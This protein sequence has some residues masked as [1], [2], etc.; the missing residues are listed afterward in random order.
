[1]ET[2]TGT[3]ET[4]SRPFNG[5]WRFAS[6]HPHG[7]VVGHLPE[8]SP[9]DVCIFQGSWKSHPKYGKQ[10]AADHV[11]VETPRDVQ[12]IKAYLARHYD[13]I[14][15][16]I[17][18][19]LVDTFGE[20]LFTVIEEYPDRLASIPGITQARATEIHETYVQIK[21]DQEFDVFFSTHGVT[22]LM[23]AKMIGRYGSKREAIRTIKENPYKLSEDLWG[24]GFKKADA[25]AVSIGIKKDSHYRLSAGLRWALE[26]AADGEGHSYLPKDALF[27]RAGKVLETKAAKKL[28]DAFSKLLTREDVILE[29]DRVYK[30]DIHRAERNTAEKLQALAGTPHER[31]MRELTAELVAEMDQDQQRA[32]ELALTSRVSVITGG[33]GV[34]KTYTVN[35]IIKC[36]GMTEKEVLLA[37]PTGKAAKRMSEMS[38]WPACTIHRLLEYSPFEEG[39]ARDHN[40]PLECKALIVD[41]TSMIDI[42]L[43][44][45]LL[46]AVDPEK[47]Q[48]IFVGDVDQLPSVGPGRVLAD[49]IDSGRIPTARLRTLHRQAAA[50]L[51]NLNA[52]AINRGEKVELGR[53]DSDFVFIEADEPEQIQR[54]M[55]RAVENVVKNLG[56]EVTDV[57][58]LCPQKRGVIG[59]VEMNKALRTILNPG[60]K[61]LE[62]RGTPF[63][64]RDRVIQLRN[65][66]QLGIFNGDIGEVQDEA[67]KETVRIRFDDK[68]IPYPKSHL[69][70]VGLAYALTI[71][72]AQGSEFPVV[73]MPIHTT[74]FLMLRRNLLYTGITRG[75]KL[76]VLVGSRKAVNIATKTVDAAERYTNLCQLIKEGQHGGCR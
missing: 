41:E 21:Q 15:P 5:G 37:A 12:G 20:T 7:T 31:M 10:F 55:T 57:Q 1:M 2:I 49:M 56:Y 61:T 38:G 17:S 30:L 73:I 75:K 67:D 48:M 4:I 60:G 54:L 65:N 33:P 71:H 69:D 40:N 9:G 29:E 16:A 22:L 44:A 58:V 68:E 24:V 39:F 50:S 45:S 46:D 28:E 42:R 74:H 62:V 34:G 63:R 43:M 18:K 23:A 36:M 6:I 11:H 53:L 25:I 3:I 70:E 59:T 51:I 72:K 19:Q 32:L 66:Y 76:V 26:A 64:V 13:W 14:G 52:Q 35:R 27:K 8:L 47:T